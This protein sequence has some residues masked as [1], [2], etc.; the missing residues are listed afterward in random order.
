VSVPIDRP[1]RGC[2]KKYVE[3][4]RETLAFANRTDRRRRQ[5]ELAKA[6]RKKNRR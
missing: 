4:T 5:R 6:S 2:G 1:A 3:G